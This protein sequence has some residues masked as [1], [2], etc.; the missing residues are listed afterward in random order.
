M[1]AQFVQQSAQPAQL[2]QSQQGLLN[3]AG[4]G[5]G[6]IT[7][8]YIEPDLSTS[9]GAKAAALQAQNFGHMADYA[10]Y[11]DTAK[12]LIGEEGAD[13]R[14][15]RGIRSRKTENALNRADA[16]R[17]RV[18]A[19]DAQNTEL[20]AE[21][22][23]D[24]QAKRVA[25][26]EAL[27]RGDK[28]ALK[29]LSSGAIS[30][31]QYMTSLMYEAK[32]GTTYKKAKTVT[33]DQEKAM[34]GTS[35][36]FTDSLLDADIA[37][38]EGVFGVNKDDVVEQYRAQFEL[39]AAELSNNSGMTA[40]EAA[41]ALMKELGDISPDTIR[42]N[43][44]FVNVVLPRAMSNLLGVTAGE[45]ASPQTLETLPSHA[46]TAISKLQ[47]ARKNGVE[48][49]NQLNFSAAE[50]EWLRANPA[51]AQQALD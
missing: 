46:Q 40:A 27:D 3:T 11:M 8:G 1:L 42:N 20:L 31:T 14:L 10:N 38:V 44:H 43:Q 25:L 16:M 45:A 35:K 15:E 47:R 34:S 48:D 24:A 39:A 4:R 37:D 7:G 12:R 6:G 26:Q 18:Q 49:A 5:F 30:P 22:K 51:I 19:M 50:A 17:T 29:G 21:A 9:E 2:S 33:A 32:N 13:R 41:N 28:A 23:K 36:K